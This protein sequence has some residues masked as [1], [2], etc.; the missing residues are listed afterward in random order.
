MNMKLKNGPDPQGQVVNLSHDA[1][2]VSTW[3]C[4]YSG[5]VL[6]DPS[7]VSC[8]RAH[9]VAL[10]P[11]A[12]RLCLACTVAQS[13]FCVF[14][15]RL[16]GNQDVITTRRVTVVF[17]NSCSGRDENFD[18]RRFYSSPPQGAGRQTFF[19]G[20]LSSGLRRKSQVVSMSARHELYAPGIR[21]SA[22]I[23]HCVVGVRFGVVC[24]VF[25]YGAPTIVRVSWRGSGCYDVLI[26]ESP[27][28]TICGEVQSWLTSVLQ[29]PCLQLD[30]HLSPP[31][32]V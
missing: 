8:R 16:S 20:K 17:S 25:V 24:T 12:S 6:V 11:S 28:C 27:Q 21:L 4:L 32:F 30:T 3:P 14:G 1:F 13:L 2:S 22:G 19:G 23:C 9:L 31:F 18:L 26:V 5:T 10:L 29:L 7:V 15:I